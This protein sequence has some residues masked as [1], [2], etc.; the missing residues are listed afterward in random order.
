MEKPTLFIGCSKKTLPLA[1]AIDQ[2][3][4]SK[5][6]TT[7]WEEEKE[8]GSIL[9]K[10]LKEIK[11][12]NFGLFILYKD[13]KTEKNDE[14]S[15]ITT[16]NVILEIGI[17]LGNKES[18]NQLI[19]LKPEVDKFQIPSDMNNIIHIEYNINLVDNNID[20]DLLI[21]LCKKIEDKINTGERTKIVPENSL[22]TTK[23]EYETVGIPISEPCLNDIDTSIL[24]IIYENILSKKY[25]LICYNQLIDL[26]ERY[27]ISKN[28]KTTLSKLER[29][30]IIEIIQN[31]CSGSE[32]CKYIAINDEWIDFIDS[33]FL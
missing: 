24:K 4:K 30:K 22:N 18:E 33:L 23:K 9:P 29:E 11:N 28:L 16:I 3:L 10:I 12:T 31:N 14:I 7:I 15:Y 6:T 13:L 26:N 5:I 17:F 1:R 25:P 8:Q 20:E 19:I 27:E 32:N 2:K 21:S